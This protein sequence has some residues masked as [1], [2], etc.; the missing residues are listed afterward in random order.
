MLKIYTLPIYNRF[1]LKLHKLTSYNARD[2]SGGVFDVFPIIGS[3]TGYGS[4]TYMVDVDIA[5]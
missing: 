2:C 1:Q 3:V 4:R 5:N